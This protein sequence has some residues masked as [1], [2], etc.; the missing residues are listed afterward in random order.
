MKVEPVKFGE[1]AK[2]DKRIQSFL[3]VVTGLREAG[4]CLVKF[5]KRR[6]VK[7]S[8]EIFLE[9]SFFRSIFLKDRVEYH[10]SVTSLSAFLD[11]IWRCNKPLASA[12]PV[13][14]LTLA[15]AGLSGLS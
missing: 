8:S 3:A 1:S 14:L 6:I 13:S 9:R 12:V 11:G 15:S 4:H 5:M 2:L 7:A 10:E